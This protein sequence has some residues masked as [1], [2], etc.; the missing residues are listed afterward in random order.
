M[1]VEYKPKDDKDKVGSPEQQQLQVGGAQGSVSGPGAGAS[2]AAKGTS[3]GRFTNL[4]SYLKANQPANFGQNLSAK[5]QQKAQ[6][7]TQS[8]DKSRQE[9]Q[10][11]TAQAIQPFQNSSQFVNQ[12][13]TDPTKFVQ[14]QPELQRFDTIRAGA[15]A[16]PKELEDAGQLQAQTQNIQGLAKLGAT[17][18]GRFNLLRTMFNQPT[19]TKGQQTLDNLILQGGPNAGLS[20]LKRVGA[21]A[22]RGLQQSLT[23]SL[24]EGQQATATAGIASEAL[25]K[26]LMTSEEGFSKS[27]QDR[28][29]ATRKEIADREN[30]IK[31]NLGQRNELTDAD[32]ATLG[33]PQNQRETFRFLYDLT[34]AQ[35]DKERVSR[36]QLEAPG[37]QSVSGGGMFGGSTTT[38]TSTNLRTITGDEAQKYLGRKAGEAVDGYKIRDIQQS[39][40]VDLTKYIESLN[41]E[42][43]TKENLA[44]KEEVKKSLALNRLGGRAQDQAFLTNEELAGSADTGFK[45]RGSDAMKALQDYYASGYD[46]GAV[47]K[48]Q[49]LSDDKLG[50]LINFLASTDTNILKAVMPFSGAGELQDMGLQA[51]SSDPNRVGLARGYTKTLLG[52]LNAAISGKPEDI[53]MGPIQGYQEMLKNAPGAVMGTAKDLT[54][55]NTY[56]NLLG[57]SAKVAANVI[58]PLKQAQ[59]AKQA[60]EAAANAARDALRF[61]NPFCLAQDT[62][63]EMEDG[64]YKAVQDIKLGDKVAFGGIVIGTGQT[65]STSIYAYNGVLMSENHAI[66]SNGVWTRAK[67]CLEAT[68]LKDIDVA[69]VHPLVTEKHIIVANNNVL[70][71]FAETDQG[72]TVNDKERLE[73]MN[74]NSEYAQA[75]EMMLNER[76]KLSA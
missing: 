65:Y 44:S 66:F 69:I 21:Q 72:Y 74:A 43:F 24:A 64:S 52:P 4:Q 46:T 35:G 68:H 41:P 47:E 32:F 10:Q 33:I 17:E 42:L 62:L 60:A 63:V 31:Q 1:P 39:T 27:I 58:N 20:S 19:Y 23:S 29:S 57:T 54:N 61:I 11:K 40:P 36:V 16:G 25:K 6:D 13:L 73:H 76:K 12:A 7:V 15:Y 3:S 34:R 70:S 55:I 8:I 75:V 22:G 56:K 49:T 28:V 37:G 30:I 71:D 2:P 14:Q 59:Q 18:G 53:V 48:T 51:Y 45:Y 9:F 38:D 50:D 5:V 67:D 26:G